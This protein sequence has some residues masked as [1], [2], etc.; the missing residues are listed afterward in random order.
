VL[1]RL[2]DGVRMARPL[3]ACPDFSY[4]AS[5]GVTAMQ[6][7]DT[8]ASWLDRADQALYAAKRAGRDR[9]VVAGPEVG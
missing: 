3:A 2:L 8:V 4:T 1:E 6:S 7:G 5:A 9:V